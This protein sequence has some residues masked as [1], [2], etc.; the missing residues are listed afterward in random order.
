MIYYDIEIFKKKI[1]I[2]TNSVCILGKCIWVLSNDEIKSKGQDRLRAMGD[3][4]TRPI[5]IGRNP[6][7][8]S[9]FALTRNRFYTYIQPIRIVVDL[10]ELEFDRKDVWESAQEKRQLQVL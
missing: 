8:V 2:S 5:C 9:S 4:Q 7:K 3:R 6:L 1:S 10:R